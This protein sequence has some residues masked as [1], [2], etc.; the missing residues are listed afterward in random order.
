MKIYF[1]YKELCNGYFTENALKVIELEG[2]DLTKAVKQELDFSVV[3]IN[4]IKA[5]NPYGLIELRRVKGN[6]L[7][8]GRL[9]LIRTR[10]GQEQVI[11][12]F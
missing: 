7:Y 8:K 2:L 10:F 12:V 5:F 1:V 11:R 3:K 6:V 4:S 9:A